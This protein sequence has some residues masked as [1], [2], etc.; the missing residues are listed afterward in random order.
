[1]GLDM[2]LK[3]GRLHGHTIQE[4]Q[5]VS[6]YL[7]WKNKGKEYSFKEWCGKEEPSEALVKELECEVHEAGQYV[8]YL[9]AFEKVGYWR[10]ANQVH[11]WFVDNVQ[12][13]DDDCGTYPVTREQ[14]EE[15]LEKCEYILNNVHLV[16][17]KV[18]SGY[19]FDEANGSVPIY[20]DGKVLDELSQLVCDR[21]LPT[22]S[23][24]FFGSLNYDGYYIS[25]I[26]HTV[27]ILKDV[28]SSTDFKTE[29]I[30]Y[31]SSW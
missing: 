11:K 12:D 29:T 25:D 14:L 19:R 16:D 5:L 3:R 13:G 7:N 17:G 4:M 10:K 15:L 22:G 21:T 1:M 31:S 26:E 9:T 28:L 8:H 27:D 6:D 23:G 20:E 24:F 30:Y 2:Y 18:I